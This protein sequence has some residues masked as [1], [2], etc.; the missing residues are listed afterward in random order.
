MIGN[1]RRAR[2]GA[3]AGAGAR[4]FIIDFENEAKNKP[5]N[6]VSSTV[7]FQMESHS[8]W[9]NQYVLTKKTTMIHL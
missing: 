8:Y 2:A 1:M 9:L 6:I 5:F 7:D 4:I 3:G